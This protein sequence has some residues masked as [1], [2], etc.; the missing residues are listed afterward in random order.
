MHTT[1]F[2]AASRGHIH[3]DWLEAWYSFSF[4]GWYDPDRVHFGALRV[5]NDDIIA[6]HSGFGWHPHSDM[7]IVTIVLSGTLTHKDST[8]GQGTLS[9]GDVQAMT[10]GKGILHSEYNEGDEEVRSLQLW[11]FPRAIDL[12]PSYAQAHLPVGLGEQRILASGDPQEG[13]L[14]LAQDMRLTR[15]R[16]APGQ[17]MDYMPMTGNVQYCF[18][19]SG[20]GVI[21]GTSLGPRDALGILDASNQ[22]VFEA[23]VE[24]FDCI[25]LDVPK[26]SV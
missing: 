10:A 3:A 18:V 15:L 22:V 4:S 6:P 16:L 9:P 23:T 20:R 21:G 11:I 25:I 19:V 24:E 7:E 17:S 8:G 26:I 13:G 2:P 14:V 5:L 1:L 12:E